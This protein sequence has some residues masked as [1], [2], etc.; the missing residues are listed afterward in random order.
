MSA[1][2]D[3]PFDLARF[4]RAQQDEFAPALRELRAGR[5]RS[6]WIWFIFPQF[7]ELG[8]SPNSIRYAIRSLA[9][10]RAY[11]AHPLLGARLEACAEAMLGHVGASADDI[12]GDVDARKLRSSATLFELVSPP[13]S[14]FA[15]IL[16]QF[17]EGERD[18]ATIRLVTQ[19]PD[20]DSRD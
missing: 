18:A 10:A 6:H 9:E 3:D 20:D 14:V 2:T 15:R 12:L 1:T 5:K 16:D 8:T 11:L 19:V 13:A 17:Y 7:R 4:V